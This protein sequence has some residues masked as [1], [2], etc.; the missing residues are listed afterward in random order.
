MRSILFRLLLHLAAPLR[1]DLAMSGGIKEE[2]R[3]KV[4]CSPLY[5]FFL[6]LYHSGDNYHT[7]CMQLTLSL[8]FKV[9]CMPS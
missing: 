3:Q 5:S 2:E 7:N 9:Q 1:Y 8:T 6:Q 4:Q